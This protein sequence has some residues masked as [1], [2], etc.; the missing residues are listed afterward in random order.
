MAAVVK[1]TV[2]RHV[3]EKNNVEN[4][5]Q[6]VDAAKTTK[7][8]SPFACQITPHSAST[9]TPKSS[10][11]IDWPGI[12]AFNNIRYEMKQTHTS[13]N[14]I[15][16][17]A[18]S[19]PADEIEVTAWKSYDVGIGKQFNWSNLKSTNDLDQLVVMY[20]PPRMND[21]W[22]SEDLEGGIYFV[23]LSC[24]NRFSYC[25]SDDNDSDTSEDDLEEGDREETIK[26]TDVFF[27]MFDC[28]DP[29]C[30]RQFRRESNLLVHIATGRHKYPRQ[31]LT[32]LDKAKL[33]YH[34]QLESVKSQQAPSL[35]N[36]TIIPNTET[37]S[38]NLLKQGWAL[39]QRGKSK[40]LLLSD[41]VGIFSS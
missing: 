13:S 7:H 12:S 16:K 35:R 20:E 29:K 14:R 28:P 39:F 9:K 31:Q 5:K 18:S 8:L 15:S 36:F 3:N 11:K 2:R 4:S 23:L 40:Q 37:I 33:S 1:C 26:T 19:H 27:K 17:R 10:K 30:I 25:F 24:P 22:M 41:A 21:S 38:N 32:L 34:N 6:F